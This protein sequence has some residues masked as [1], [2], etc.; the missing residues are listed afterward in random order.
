MNCG[1][2]DFISTATIFSILFQYEHYLI[3]QE[4]TVHPVCRGFQAAALNSRGLEISCKNFK[5]FLQR[6]SEFF[7]K[8]ETVVSCSIFPMTVFATGKGTVHNESQLLFWHKHPTE[9]IIFKSAVKAVP[10]ISE[11]DH[12]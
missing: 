1:F 2:P 3:L 4:I 5:D 7:S 10:E 6:Q 11:L 12:Q 9:L 8:T